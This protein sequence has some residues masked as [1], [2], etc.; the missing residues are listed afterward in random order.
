[1]TTLVTRHERELI[2]DL[3][4][5]R[6]QNLYLDGALSAFGHGRTAD[7]VS[8]MLSAFGRFDTSFLPRKGRICFSVRSI[9]LG[10]AFTD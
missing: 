3:Y 9:P 4:Q 2:R 8:T 10:F 6:S 5:Q 1:M 7:A